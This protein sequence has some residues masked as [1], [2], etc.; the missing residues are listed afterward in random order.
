MKGKMSG[1]VGEEMETKSEKL[2]EAKSGR[3]S[4]TSV[5]SAQLIE[6]K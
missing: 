3:N 6:N 5:K 2:Q 4:E 1:V